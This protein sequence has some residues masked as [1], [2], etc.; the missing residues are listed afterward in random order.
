MD[1]EPLCVLDLK[2]TNEL[3]DDLNNDIFSLLN[4]DIFSLLNNDIFSLV[5]SVVEDSHEI[6]LVTRE[7]TQG[8]SQFR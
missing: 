4:N 3:E 2:H 8:E 6:A 7:E 1:G 5:C